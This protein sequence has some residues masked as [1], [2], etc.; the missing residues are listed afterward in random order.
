[1]IVVFLLLFGADP[2]GLQAAFESAES[3]D[4]TY[5]LT[6]FKVTL[7]N[8]KTIKKLAPL[9]EVKGEAT[10]S[11][12]QPA[13]HEI[14]RVT[15]RGKKT[16]E[17]WM[18]KNKIAFGD[19]MMIDPADDKLWVALRTYF[20]PDLPKGAPPKVEESVQTTL[21]AAM[22][23]ADKLDVTYRKVKIEFPAGGDGI[24]KVHLSNLKLAGDVN[25]NAKKP[26]DAVEIVFANKETRIPIYLVGD[27]AFWGDKRWKSVTLTRDSMWRQMV[28][29][30]PTPE[31]AGLKPDPDDASGLAAAIEAADSLEATLVG[32]ETEYVK[33][34]VTFKKEEIKDWAKL[35]LGVGKPGAYNGKDRPD[36][37]DIVVKKGKDSRKFRL[38]GD[39]LVFDKDRAVKMEQ[40]LILAKIIQRLQKTNR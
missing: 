9:V 33:G 15:V 19:Q 27:I 7:V 16:T 12:G 34:S 21:N 8:P 30:V 22:K 11:L 24:R 40:G 4:M 29:I 39:T 20:G 36:A 31:S 13:T 37:I 5:D 38:I 18:L 1:M 17:F 35:A 23:T 26:E 3:V 10:K 6:G 25:Q 14:I 2:T 32:G 28:H